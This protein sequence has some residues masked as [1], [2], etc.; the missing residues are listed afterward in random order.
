[1]S[2]EN[3]DKTFD[4]IFYAPVRRRRSQVYSWWLE[5]DD[6]VEE[7]NFTEHTLEWTQVLRRTPL[8]QDLGLITENYSNVQDPKLLYYSPF[9]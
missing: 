2:R 8:T 5:Q 6:S 7:Y 4:S 1:M 3:F 9:G